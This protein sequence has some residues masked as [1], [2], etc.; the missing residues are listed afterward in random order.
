[1]VDFPKLRKEVRSFLTKEDGKMTKE[2]LIKAGVIITAFS[3]AAAL[4]SSEASA[5][6]VDGCNPEG[7]VNDD[8]G[9]PTPS[10]YTCTT[11]LKAGSK[12]GHD[13]DI[14]FELQGNQPTGTH[15]HCADTFQWSDHS[16]YATYDDGGGGMF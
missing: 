12:T 9:L 14:G 6:H 8:C 1:M 5:G 11:G 16:D 2:N 4:N 13:N 3:A 15:S 7:W 10:D